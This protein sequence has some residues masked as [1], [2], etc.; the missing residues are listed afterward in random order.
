LDAR[1]RLFFNNTKYVICVRSNLCDHPLQVLSNLANVTSRSGR[2]LTFN[3]P[4]FHFNAR[5][6]FFVEPLLEP[7]E[8][9]GTAAF[10]ANG[11]PADD[12][13]NSV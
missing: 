13:L 11:V 3:E 4:R 6:G 10:N 5:F 9:T 1:F 8:V 7:T 12:T 2:A